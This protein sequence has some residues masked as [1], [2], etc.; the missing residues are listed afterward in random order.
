MPWQKNSA[1]QGLINGILVIFISVESSVQILPW[2]NSDEL[3]P[4]D[5]DLAIANDWLASF[6][7]AF[8][9]SLKFFS[10]L[11]FIEVS[12]SFNLL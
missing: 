7:Q 12:D 1:L 2:N 9:V 5:S 10:V 11:V 3:V 6:P 8:G 4:F